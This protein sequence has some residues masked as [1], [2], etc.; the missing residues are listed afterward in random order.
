MTSLNGI[1]I[2]KKTSVG[3][4]PSDTFSVLPV[5]VCFALFLTILFHTVKKKICKGSILFEVEILQ[6]P[7]LG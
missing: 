5:L 3:A 7:H 6:G 1:W 2:E 4:T